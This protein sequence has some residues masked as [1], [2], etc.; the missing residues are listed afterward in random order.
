MGLFGNSYKNKRVK[1]R[2]ILDYYFNEG[3]GSNFA[4]CMRQCDA[5]SFYSLLLMGFSL[6][7]IESR[8]DSN[9][10]EQELMAS[11]EEENTDK[12]SFYNSL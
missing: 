5:R 9:K 11:G 1:F 12:Q 8:G 6:D 10:E 2:H 4:Q 7:S 3:S